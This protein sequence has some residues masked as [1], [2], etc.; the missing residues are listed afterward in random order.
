ME[1]IKFSIVIP[2][3]NAE[4]YIEE[5]LE[6]VLRQT[7][8]HFE[9]ILINDGS[10][11][12]SG[13]IC[14]EY[15]RKDRRIRYFHQENRGVVL[16]RRVGIENV[17]GDYA[18]FLDSDD[19]WDTNILEILYERIS[20]YASDL[21]LFG[22]KRVSENKNILLEKNNLFTDNKLFEGEE[23]NELFK[24]IL[25][26]PE[27]N[28]LAFKAIKT[29]LLDNE[30]YLKFQD[31][32]TGEDLLESLPVF[33][34]AKKILY[35]NKT[36]YNYRYNN[37]SVT[38]KFYRNRIYDYMRVKEEILKYINIESSDYEEIFYSGCA[39]SI[40]HYLKG[41][42]GNYNRKIRLEIFEDIVK[43]NLVIEVLKRS[44]ILKLNK[45]DKI[46]I[47]CFKKKMY[48]CL[49]I[50]LRTFNFLRKIKNS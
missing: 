13:S 32:K 20:K 25:R 21:I 30:E 42:S 41:L 8:K 38:N 36:L 5:C 3:Y 29:S 34:K 11:D 24:L 23:K 14:K 15:S 19:Y 9:I 45:L 31:I 6:S 50:I 39:Q 28:N 40:I 17:T 2:V 37:E 27:L 44:S 22:Y 26:G 4:K 47:F 12:K 43:I 1:N 7:Y 46:I 10:N 18:L 48:F 33:L 35:I 49:D 16:T